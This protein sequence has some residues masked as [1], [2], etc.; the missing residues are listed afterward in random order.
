MTRRIVDLR[1]QQRHIKELT[2]HFAASLGG[3][4]CRLIGELA[5]R[6]EKIARWPTLSPGER[7]RWQVGAAP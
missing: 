2:W 6:P 1:P 3:E 5:L 4:A 7:K